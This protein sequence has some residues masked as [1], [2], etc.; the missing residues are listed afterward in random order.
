ML[1]CLAGERVDWGTAGRRCEVGGMVG[2]RCSAVVEVSGS[3]VA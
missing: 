1:I 2:S 3:W